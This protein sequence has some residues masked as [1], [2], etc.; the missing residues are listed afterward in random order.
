MSEPLKLCPF[1]GNPAKHRFLATDERHRVA[2]TNCE[3]QTGWAG[4][5]ETALSLWDQR[6]QPAPLAWTA[7]KPTVEGHY[8]LEIDGTPYQ[9][10]ML[11]RPWGDMPGDTTIPYGEPG[12]FVVDAIAHVL[13]EDFRI[14]GPVLRPAEPGSEVKP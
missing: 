3:A 2:C 10:P 11:I 5:R 8:W 7:E 9:D 4:D 6:V 1:C 12:A 14:A 13:R